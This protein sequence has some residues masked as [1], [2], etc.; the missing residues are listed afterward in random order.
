MKKSLYI[1]FVL[2]MIAC[3]GGPDTSSVSSTNPPNAPRMISYSVLN[4]YP[5][6][7]SYFT[8]GLLIYKSDLYESTGE[9][10]RSVL[11]KTDL[12]TGKA[13]KK[14]D[15]DNKYFGEGIAILNDTIYQ[16]TYQE[17]VGFMYS[18][19]D[20]KKLGEFTF[21]S[22]EGWGMTT[23][24]Q[25]IIASDGSSNL[26]YYEPS[27]FKFLRTLGVTEAGS[28]AFNLNELEYIDGYIYANQWQYPYILKIDPSDGKVVG[29][30][31]LSQITT[32]IKSKYP[33]AEF[34]N[35]IAYDSATKKMYITGKWW[36]EL[37]E[38]ELSK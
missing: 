21:A 18:V 26:Y 3:N 5:H 25:Y 17:K 15:L 12:K 10:G 36:P 24:G 4:T 7:T 34:L 35:G 2:F 8:E 37:Y 14:I 38:I 1:L 16:L 22:R 31:D 30:I 29:K 33:F 27:T 11:V 9:K 28:P 6:D 19:K 20:F 13:L 32:T 23:D